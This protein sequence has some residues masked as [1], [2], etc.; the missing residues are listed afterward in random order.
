MSIRAVTYG[1]TSVLTP[2][3]YGT[4][5][6]QPAGTQTRRDGTTMK[7][8]ARSAILMTEY[9]EWAK[10]VRKDFP[11]QAS[12]LPA[13]AGKV[14]FVAVGEDQRFYVAYRADKGKGPLEIVCPW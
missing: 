10:V 6:T 9:Q 1:L 2:V 3:T 13:G 5:T 11:V 4:N 8:I 14:M 12:K 7:I